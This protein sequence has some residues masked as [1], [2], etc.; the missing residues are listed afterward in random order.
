MQ[1]RIKSRNQGFIDLT[2]PLTKKSVYKDSSQEKA[3]GSNVDRGELLFC[4]FCSQ[5]F[6]WRTFPTREK[7]LIQNWLPVRKPYLWSSKL[8]ACW[9]PALEDPDLK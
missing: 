2:A 4:L 1:S 8:L 6:S 9:I 5:V 7:E 3:W